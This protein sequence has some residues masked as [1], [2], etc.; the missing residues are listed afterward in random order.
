M[1]WP[2]MQKF[3]SIVPLNDSDTEADSFAAMAASEGTCEAGRSGV[4]RRLLRR[5]VASGEEH[6]RTPHR[7]WS[8]GDDVAEGRRDSTLTPDA[9]A[10]VA[11]ASVGAMTRL[12]SLSQRMMAMRQ[13][14][15][16]HHTMDEL[17]RINDGAILDDFFASLPQR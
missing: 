1:P 8:V 5:L 6:P 15:T 2:D 13:R 3:D 14:R 10:S 11:S 16:R 12:R 17:R 4:F 7:A 9:S